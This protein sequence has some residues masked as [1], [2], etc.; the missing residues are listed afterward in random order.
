MSQAVTRKPRSPRCK[1][2]AICGRGRGL[3]PGLLVFFF[4]AGGLP[5]VRGQEA[6]RWKFREGD[7]LKYTNEQSTLMIAKVTGKE[8]KQKR[9]QSVTYSWT[10]KGVS[11]SGEADITM[12]IDRLTVK[13]EAPP[14]MPFEFD[15]ASP[16]T[17]VPEPFQAEAG[18]IKA[19]VGAE[20][21]FKMKPNGEVGN[22]SIPESTL[23]KLTEGLPPDEQSGQRRPVSEQ[24]LKDMVVQSS[25]PVFPAGTLEPGKSWSAKPSKLSAELGTLVLD[26]SF[27]FQGTDPKNPDLVQF[28]M[29]GRVTI[30]PGPN[31]TVKIRSQDGKGSVT[32]DKQNGRMTNMRGTQKTEM[33]IATQGQELDQT[34]DTTS[35]LTLMP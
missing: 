9:S 31:V 26:K 21:S 13:V 2:A 3:V 20:Y 12:R 29:E 19:A 33:V 8:R 16:A 32:F 15:S 6:V 24:V 28:T 10:I 1:G 27:T 4:C 7:V 22:I 5:D 11:D 18:L 34:T 25:P 14:F 30:E 35:V 23:K 17:E